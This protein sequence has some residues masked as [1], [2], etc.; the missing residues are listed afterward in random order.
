MNQ[1][2]WWV[3]MVVRLSAFD[4]CKNSKRYCAFFVIRRCQ[5]NQRQACTLEKWLLA[6]FQY[7]KLNPS[8]EWKPQTI[9]IKSKHESIRL[10]KNLKMCCWCSW[11][12]T[13][14]KRLNLKKKITNDK[15]TNDHEKGEIYIC[16]K[17]EEENPSQCMLYLDKWRLTWQNKVLSAQSIF[18][19][20]MNNF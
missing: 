17:P 9:R 3:P 1:F 20:E 5:R 8:R 14:S 19:L 16:K 10:L 2:P 6:I 18:G 11:Q 4:I 7:K 12:M 13:G 15:Y